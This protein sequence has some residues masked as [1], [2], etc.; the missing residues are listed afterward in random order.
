MSFESPNCL[1]LS[2]PPGQLQRVVRPRGP[3][4]EPRGLSSQRDI[5][6]LVPV[7][8][9]EELLRFEIRPEV[10]KHVE[11][12]VDR[13]HRQQTAQPSAASPPHHQ[14]DSRDFGR[15]DALHEWP[16]LAA[17]RVT[18][19]RR[20]LAQVPQPIVVDQEIDLRRTAAECLPGSEGLQFGREKWRVV[21]SDHLQRSVQLGKSPHGIDARLPKSRRLF[22]RSLRVVACEPVDGQ[23]LNSESGADVIELE[24]GLQA[25]SVAL[26]LAH[27]FVLC[28]SAITIWDERH[29]PRNASECWQIHERYLAFLK[30]TRLLHGSTAPV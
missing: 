28:P 1:E 22:G 17:G 8:R 16:S 30:G 11:I 21:V 24:S 29:M 5:L 7:Q 10:I 23:F 25:V 14:V 4:L 18:R 19:I 2:C 13:L 26:L 3:N 27:A 6:R 20:G 15:S 12:R 9:I